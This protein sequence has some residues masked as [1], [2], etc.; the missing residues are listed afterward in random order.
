MAI[1]SE[2]ISIS[3]YYGS[4]PG[5]VIAGGG[6]TSYKE[7]DRMWIKASGTSLADI[8]E[9]GFVCLSRTKLN[10]VTSTGY[11]KDPFKREE[12]VKRDLRAA[13]TENKNKRP[14]VE[15][16]LHNLFSYPFVIHTHPTVVNAL[17]CSVNAE[18]ETRNLFG[19]EVMFVE[20]TDPGY[21]LFKRTEKIM[22]EYL[23]L[24]GNEPQVVFLQNHGLIV[25]G[26]NAGDIQTLSDRII[27]TISSRFTKRL[28]ELDYLPPESDS[29][30]LLDKIN[31]YL[32]TLEL[33][34]VYGNNELTGLFVQGS[35]E[36]IKTARPF[37]PDNIVYCR[38]EYLFSGGEAEKVISDIESFKSRY[39][40][41]PMIIGLEKTGLV[42]AGKNKQSAARSMEVF[43]DMMQISFLSENFGGQKFLTKEQIKFIDIWE[44]ENYR[45]SV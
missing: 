12:E 38:S 30:V 7:G 19:N 10:K 5:Y 41:F 45:R 29:E 28:P 35:T 2:L 33:V 20:Y 42:S 18:R 1:N 4:N 22:S 6:N 24:H 21:T 9:S 27:G 26:E 34:S 39:N 14:S 11:S 16:S 32:S 15:T 37:T 43:Q 8:D 40:Y 23:A 3:R 13:V 25:C 44:A 31:D 36:F 17:L